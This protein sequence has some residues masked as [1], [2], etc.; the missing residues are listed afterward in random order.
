MNE[1]TCGMREVYPQELKAEIFMFLLRAN[2]HERRA[3]GFMGPLPKAVKAAKLEN[4]HAPNYLHPRTYDKYG[5]LVGE[6]EY[7]EKYGDPV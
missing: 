6:E 1:G 5:V 3:K 4:L 2:R 7:Y